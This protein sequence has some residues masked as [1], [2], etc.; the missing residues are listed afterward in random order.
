M[1]TVK[2]LYKV[3]EQRTQTSFVRFMRYSGGCPGFLETTR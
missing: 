3:Y 1:L 2:H